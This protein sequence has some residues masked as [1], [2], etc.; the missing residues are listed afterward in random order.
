MK[1]LAAS[2]VAAVMTTAQAGN[3]QTDG[4]W[5]QTQLAKM[6]QTADV[7][8]AADFTNEAT[9]P[10]DEATLNDIAQSQGWQRLLLM[11]ASAGKSLTD[12][13]AFFLSGTQDAK[14]ELAAQLE[15]LLD[16]D[17]SRT[18]KA[19]HF[20]ARQAFLAQQLA[21]R[22]VAVQAAQ[23]PKFAAW[24]A[25]VG[26]GEMSLVFATQSANEI[27]SAFAH[28]FLQ[29]GKQQTPADANLSA[30]L[31]TNLPKK[32]SADLPN[33]AQSASMAINFTVSSER[34]L[35]A[36][37][38]SL[39]G[40]GRGIFQI[41]PFEDFAKNYLANER[42]LWIYPLRLNDDERMRLLQHLYEIRHVPRRYAFTNENC[43]SEILRLIDVAT[44]G[45]VQNAAGKVITPS[46]SVQ[47]LR[48]ANIAKAGIFVPA[49]HR[50]DGVL[51]PNND[52][53]NAAPM[54]KISAGLNHSSGQNAASVAVVAAY[55]DWLDNPTGMRKFHQLQLLSARINA[56]ENA[57]RLNEAT[58]FA[59]SSLNP[60]NG[61][62]ANKTAQAF[63]LGL[64][65]VSDASDRSNTQ[66][67][68]LAA[69]VARG[70]AWQIGKAKP[71]SLDDPD[72]ACY[73]M[74]AAGVEL[75]R[76][77]QGYRTHIGARVGCMQL[78]GVRSRAYVELN[79]P[80]Y[81]HNDTAADA[82]SGYWQPSVSIAAQ[83][84]LSRD[85]ALRTQ[86][87]RHWLHHAADNQA[88]IEMIRYF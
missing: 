53:S 86:L 36:V 48:Q 20:V 22:G 58:L 85:L 1:K 59:M 16:D 3:A 33:T 57:V 60:V 68:V 88:R 77:N 55:Q 62:N 18:D 42:D 7:A 2:I 17:P 82:R 6:A 30:D 51:P 5:V 83:Y 37:A 31:S 9:L 26:D 87:S 46:E 84:D 44:G 23:C 14:A 4:L 25:S 27:A 54:H 32:P 81:Y 45:D 29:V 78:L 38:K 11:D 28:T 13:A 21:K 79:A 72:G 8:D 69:D 35:S 64:R 56:D 43:A 52:P 12:D 47:R 74:A 67:L 63:S 50:S 71:N 76:V 40:Q 80:Y 24:R 34:G 39:V 75:G 61:K 10:I 49:Y 15:L 70:K 66:H 65:T 19:C 73:A 41:E